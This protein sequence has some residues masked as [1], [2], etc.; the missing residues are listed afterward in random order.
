M[1]FLFNA[2]Q[3]KGYQNILRLSWRPFAFTQA[4]TVI[5]KYRQVWNIALNFY[6]S[7]FRYVVYSTLDRSFLDLHCK[8]YVLGNSSLL[9]S[10]ILI[11]L[12]HILIY[13]I[14]YLLTTDYHILFVK[15]MV[16]CKKKDFV[17]WI[18]FYVR[19][20]H[21]IL[22]QIIFLMLPLNV[23]LLLNGID[24]YSSKPYMG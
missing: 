4:W 12:Y 13:H 3:F 19:T 23:L 20:M 2:C 11:G 15:I 24:C 5:D 22:S 16:K 8:V 17:G 9:S 7:C 18:I 6:L 21:L 10:P 1:H 14:S